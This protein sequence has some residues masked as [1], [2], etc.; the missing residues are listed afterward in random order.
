MQPVSRV[1]LLPLFTLGG[2]LLALLA[3]S[4]AVG[5][6]SRS[7]EAAPPLGLPRPGEIGFM[8]GPSAGT[9]EAIARRYFVA[10]AAAL[11]LTGVG[12][13]DLALVRETRSQQSGLTHLYFVQRVRGIEVFNGVLNVSISRDGRVLTVGNRT[14]ATPGTPDDGG[15]PTLSAA[16]AAEAAL[17]HLRLPPTEPLRRLS[18]RRSRA[19][20]ATVSSGGVTREPIALHLVYQPTGEGL[21]LAWNVSLQP[22][23]GGDWWNVRVDAA[24]G[25]LLDKNNWT[26]TD[27]FEPI[28]FASHEAGTPLA[29]PPAPAAFSPDAYRVF[30]LPFVNPHDPGA[31]HTLVPDPAELAVSPFGWHDTDGLAGAEYTDTRGNN[32]FAQHSG[33]TIYR[34]DGGPT[35]TFDFPFDP[36]LPPTEDSNLAAS[37]TSLF[38]WNNIAHDLF[39]LHGFDTASGNFQQNPYGQGGLSN[40]PVLA[41]G[42]H[43]IGTNGG[44]FSTPPDGSSPRMVL[45]HFTYTT[46]HRDSA[47]D[48]QIILHEYGHGVSSRLTGGP[49]NASCLSNAEQGGEG[50]SDWLAL[51]L[52]AKAT[53]SATTPRTLGTYLLG[54]P[55]DGPGWRPAPYTTDL[56]VNDRTYGDLATASGAHGVGFVWA[57]I[58]WEAYWALVSEHGFDEDFYHGTGGNLMALRLVIEGMKLQPCA[59]GFVDARDAILSADIALY[60]GENQCLLWQAFAKRGMGYSAT[61]GSPQA[62]GDEVEAFNLP[63]SCHFLTVQSQST[64]ICAGQSASYTLTV[65]QGFDP[66]V[67]LSAA[68]HPAGTS[69]PFTPNPV[70]TLP[71]LTQLTISDTLGAIPG[72]YPITLTGTDASA[73]HTATVSLSLYDAPPGS[74]TLQSPANGATGITRSPTFAWAGAAQ[75]Q[76]Y[77]LEVDD[78][79]NFGSPVYS[80][81]VQTTTHAIAL[82]LAPLT[83]YHWRLHPRNPCGDGPTSPVFT[84]TTEA[85]PLILLVDDD[86]NQPD[87]RPHYLDALNAAGYEADLWNTAGSDAEPTSAE[88]AAYQAVIWFTGSASHAQTGPG[89]VGSA[90]LSTF[91]DSGRCLFLSSQDY[92]RARGITPFATTYLGLAG[93]E[94]DVQHTTVEGAGLLFEGLGPYA[95]LF[96]GGGWSDHV[97]PVPT[98]QVGFIGN[99]GN[100]GIYRDSGLYRTVFLGFGL[101]DIPTAP[102]RGEVVGRFMDWCQTGLTGTLTGSV[103][104]STSG[105][106]LAGATIRADDGTEPQAVTTDAQGAY[107]LP[108]PTGNYT[109]TVSASGYFTESTSVTVSPGQTVTT[110]FALLPLVAPVYG[111]ELA[112]TP[113]AQTGSAGSIVAYTLRVTNTGSVTDSFTLEASGAWTTT[114][115]ESNLTLGAGQRADLTA[116][117]TIPP[118]A[119]GGTSQ[120]SLVTIISQGKPTVT[121]T[122]LLT[123]TVLPH[124]GMVLSPDEEAEGLPGDSVAY[125][126]TLTNTGN[127]TDTFLLTL[128][129]G[130]WPTTPPPA[131]L[132]L[133]RGASVSF[134]LHVQVPAG[135]LHGASDLAMLTATSQ[136]NPSVSQM[137]H[138]TTSAAATYG[139]V[140][141]LEGSGMGAPG[142]PIRYTLHLTNTGNGTD[143]FDLSASGS[144]PITLSQP[145]ITLAAGAHGAVT[146]DITV[147]ADAADGESATL[148]LLIRSQGN[149]STTQT[150]IATPTS[151]W[152]RLYLPV[153]RR[154]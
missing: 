127:L 126:V 15:L 106:P 81:T 142:T 133:G 95:L 144:W 27:I 111:V 53:E 65:G 99:Q 112:A 4:G 39:A 5:A 119:V 48:S 8:T 102:E 79:P 94:Q 69:A 71:A 108:L 32:S 148:T 55:H 24:T 136:G 63:T 90:A 134:T 41:E 88:L 153:L 154:E 149:P 26:V 61:Q 14:V 42:L 113:T 83:T 10:H 121:A 44:A 50:W 87:M 129:E 70:S 72:S 74:P 131:S 132:T 36:T 76:E 84:F 19:Q 35:L 105:Q 89:S 140:A 130:Q 67:T 68:G 116:S 28:G 75:A 96:Q 16:Q 97:S 118:D 40:D 123:T 29:P 38:Y 64:A 23:D 85:A 115:S 11:G 33:G 110:D 141:S 125:V 34:P 60:G 107:T 56:S 13:A 100:A 47:L 135:A 146:L 6:A 152:H 20:E 7:T 54:Q 52:T 9:P 145:T 3:L 49:S 147:P 138:L 92:L 51:V 114:L 91:L 18:Q 43:P 31:I 128:I 46:P 124:Y 59:P 78:S 17:R 22:R 62:L 104:D 66:P 93:A 73:A 21:R 37:I 12:M 1:R 101:E 122:Q 58:L 57:S 45:L 2:L 25:A 143:T 86:R 117:V 103:T 139:V 98:A 120:P 80:V 82:S 77:L 30:P 151:T 150:P 109:L 137:R